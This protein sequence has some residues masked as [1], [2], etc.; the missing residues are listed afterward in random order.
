MKQKELVNKNPNLEQGLSG[1]F[2]PITT[3]LKENEKTE[4]K[5]VVEINLF[6][7]K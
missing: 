1:I 7:F 5:K 4:I 3:P 2:T 6:S